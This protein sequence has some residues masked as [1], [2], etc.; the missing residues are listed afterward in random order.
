MTTRTLTSETTGPVL[1]DATLLAHGG[2]ITVKAE[3]S[4]TRATLTIRTADETGAAAD[5]VKAATLRQSGNRLTALVQGSGGDSGTTIVMGGGASVIQTFGTVHGSVTGM[6]ITGNGNFVSGNGGDVIING[7]R[8]SGNGATVIQGTSPIEITAVVPEGSSVEG[9][10][11]SATIEAVGAL[12][13]VSGKTQSGS[14]RAGH[15]SRVEAK[16]Q[17]GSVLVERAAHIEAKTQSGSIKLGRTDV[18]SAKTMSGSIQIT[19]FGGTV[20]AD[21]MSGSI[22]IH[23]TAGGD[24]RAKSMSGSVTVTATE[25]A[26]ADDLDVRADSMSGRVSIPQR[27][28]GDSGPRRRR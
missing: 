28:S 7:V 10:T 5:A 11:T 20:K 16:T 15:V 23:A 24:V 27:R 26:L 9:H 3:A 12:L 8:V 25:T 6:T 18:V 2:L 19:D 13:N 14:V 21:T 1:I 17:S 4:C 22:R